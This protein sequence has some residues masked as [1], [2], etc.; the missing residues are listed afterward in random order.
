MQYCKSILLDLAA[1]CFLISG[2]KVITF[3]NP[4]LG[5]TCVPF[6]HWACSLSCAMALEIPAREE[7]IAAARELDRLYDAYIRE[8]QRQYHSSAARSAAGNLLCTGRRRR[9]MPR[10]SWRI[11]Q[12]SN[13]SSLS[14]ND[15]SAEQSAASQ[16]AAN[17]CFAGCRLP[18]C[19]S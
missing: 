16:S 14:H 6:Q 7:Q 13:E 12:G 9:T 3:K 4:Y 2:F 11:M 5:N 10:T 19:V 8:C 15:S 1:A 17:S 18:C